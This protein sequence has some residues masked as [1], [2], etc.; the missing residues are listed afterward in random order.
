MSAPP[1]GATLTSGCARRYFD[2][3]PGLFGQHIRRPAGACV[4]H[5]GPAW[6][7]RYTGEM[8]LVDVRGHPQGV[9]RDRQAGIHPGA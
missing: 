8:H 5:T 6:L 4:L 7:S 3:K 1:E 2:D 9:G